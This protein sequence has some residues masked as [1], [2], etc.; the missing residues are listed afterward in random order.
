MQLSIML[1]GSNSELRVKS[2][3][4][5]LNSWLCKAL[6]LTGQEK[7]CDNAKR[8]RKRDFCSVGD[9]LT[10]RLDMA[11][12]GVIR[13]WSSKGL[14]GV[15]PGRWV[16]RQYTSRYS[17]KC[18]H[19]SSSWF[20]SRMTS[21]ISYKQR[22]TKWTPSNMFAIGP[23]SDL[24]RILKESLINLGL[25]GGHWESLSAAIICTFRCLLWDLPLDL[26]S[27]WSTCQKTVRS[28]PVPHRRIGRFTLPLARKP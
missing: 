1:R 5:C 7:S 22:E 28:A 19:A 8:W 14:R 18:S 6:T 20:S 13:L 27:L 10:C 23:R 12:G 9:P 21:N 11:E 2:F 15:L 24:V 16:A 4:T 17:A 25:T 3:K 26:T